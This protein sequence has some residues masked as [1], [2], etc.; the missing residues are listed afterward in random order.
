MN[1]NKKFW[2][3]YAS[4]YA[5]FMKNAD[6]SY[7]EISTKVKPYLS[8]EMKVLELACGSGQLTFRLAESAK[9]WEATDFAEHR[10]Q[11]VC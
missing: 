7:D 11:M 10:R 8:R 5:L 2:Q 9:S 6:K 1:D 3:R 4:I